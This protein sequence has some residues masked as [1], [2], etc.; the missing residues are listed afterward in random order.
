MRGNRLL[1]EVRISYEIV[2]AQSAVSAA[3]IFRVRLTPEE[4][5]LISRL[6][7]FYSGNMGHSQIHADGWASD[8][9]FPSIRTSAR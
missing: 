8:A 9:R 5:N 4:H 6:H 2:L 7:F 3:K 1:M